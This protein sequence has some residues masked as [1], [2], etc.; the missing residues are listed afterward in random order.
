MFYE[1]TGWGTGKR[2]EEYHFKDIPMFDGVAVHD[3]KK[4]GVRKPLGGG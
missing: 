4:T 1:R 3:M 2:G